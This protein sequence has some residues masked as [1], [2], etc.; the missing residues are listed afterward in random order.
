MKTILC[1]GDSNTWG[2]DP[3][4]KERMYINTRWPGVL[5]NSLGRDYFVIEEGLCGRTTVWDDPIE[6]NKNGKMY[7]IPCL[8]S[9]SPLDLV[10]IMLGTN[11]LKHRFSL[12]AFDIAQ[13][14]GLLASMVQR[15]Q[16]GPNGMAPE[17]LL[18]APPAIGRQ[19]CYFEMFRG[20]KEKSE[21]FSK[22]FKM[23]ADKLKCHFLDARS[24]I[25][26]SDLDG[27]HFESQEHK[28]LG[29]AVSKIVKDILP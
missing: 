2:A 28:K 5:R 9:H 10:I 3:E 15:S 6:E 12:T 7:L 13:G 19:T 8:D 22:Y 17:V 24:V 1:Y 23:V 4:K 27:I 25:R 14:A 16:Y 26:S 18:I 20:A 21:E 29:Q 11:D